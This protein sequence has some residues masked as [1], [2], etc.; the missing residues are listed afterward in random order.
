MK[1]EGE[2]IRVRVFLNTFQ[3]W[4]MQPVYEAIVERARREG[5]AGATVLAG[6]EGFG[7]THVLLKDHPWRLANDREIVVELVDTQE[8]LTGFLARIEP[9]LRDAIVTTERAHVIFYRRKGE[10]RP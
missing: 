4:H 9:M 10:A 5:L 7:Q 3:K 1:L 8:A 2:N 6:V